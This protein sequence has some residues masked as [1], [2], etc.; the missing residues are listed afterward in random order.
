MTFIHPFS[1]VPL[2]P[3]F[4]GKNRWTSDVLHTSLIT[5]SPQRIVEMR[6]RMSNIEFIKGIAHQLSEETFLDTDKRNL[7]V[8]DVMMSEAKCDQ[9]IADL[10]SKGSHH[11]NV[12]VIYLTQ[13]L[14]P[15]GKACR[16]IAFNTQNL[17]LFNNPIDR[18]QV[19]T[20]S[21]R[22]IL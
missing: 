16:D 5:P 20:L 4:S 6:K 18:Q 15:Q 11:R 9:R 21:K 1:M 3:S 2:G 22:I 8:F 19:A 12:S 13:N 14:F 17:V 10:F 7:I